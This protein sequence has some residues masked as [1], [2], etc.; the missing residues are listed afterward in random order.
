MTADSAIVG[1]KCSSLMQRLVFSCVHIPSLDS[2]KNAQKVKLN[3]PPRIILMNSEIAPSKNR[4]F[5]NFSICCFLLQVVSMVS[6]FEL[7]TLASHLL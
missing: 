6:L 2:L 4:G 3:I 7:G 5:A 1:E